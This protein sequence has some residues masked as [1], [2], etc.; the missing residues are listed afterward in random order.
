MIV[1]GFSLKLD[2]SSSKSLKSDDQILPDELVGVSLQ[3][4]QLNSEKHELQMNVRWR[5]DTHCFLLTDEFAFLTRLF[6]VLSSFLL[7]TL[8]ISQIRL[9]LSLQNLHRFQE[10]LEDQQISMYIQIWIWFGVLIVCVCEGYALDC[11]WNDKKRRNGFETD[12]AMTSIVKIFTEWC[13]WC[14]NSGTDQSHSLMNIKQTFYTW[15]NSS[16]L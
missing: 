8:F 3:Q 6:L 10:T 1:I 11:F 2:S 12:L 4:T 15:K 13:F 14:S 9:H 5:R 7:Q 16:V